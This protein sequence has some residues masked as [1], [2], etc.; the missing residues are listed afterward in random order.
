VVGFF[1]LVGAGRSELMKL[2]Y[3]AVKRTSGTVSILPKG[4]VA[5]TI[6]ASIRAGL[7]FCSEDRKKEGVIPIRSLTENVNISGRRH[8]NKLKVL[9]DNKKEVDNA[10][11]YVERLTIRTPS[12][13]QLVGNLSG[14][15][16]QKVLLARW[17]CENIKAIILDEPTR[18]ID[19]GAKRE[20]YDIIFELAKTGIGVV[21]VSSELPEILGICDRILVMCDGLVEAEIRRDEAT[22]ELVLQ[23][24][25]P[26]SEVP[27]H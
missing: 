6:P 2:V 4:V 10:K 9:I 8:F 13:N 19:V 20:I 21:I 11:T 22:Q 16:Q 25:L 3:S 12:I 24:A 26:K 15:N 14:G 23:H 17:L 1:G 7:V 18:G 5:P 27:V